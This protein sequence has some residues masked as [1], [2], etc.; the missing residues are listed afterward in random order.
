MTKKGL[1][2]IERLKLHT[3]YEDEC[4]IWTGG[5]RGDGYGSVG[6]EGKNVAPHI[7]SY[8][9]FKGAIP[10]GHLVLH[11]CDRRL[12]WNPD[13]L[14]AGTHRDNTQDALSKGRMAIGEANG[15]A[16]ATEELVRAI[17]A[18]Y[19]GP[20]YG[21]LRRL[22]RKHGLAPTTIKKIVLGITWKHLLPST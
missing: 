9:H 22:S 20:R 16:L 10:E 15:K 18:E 3:R 1:P 4:W 7:V 11:T 12:C 2:I 17:R 14:F 8:K 21:E 19:Q 5:Q 13:H 6:F